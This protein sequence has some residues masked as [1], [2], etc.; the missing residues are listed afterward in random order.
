M[1]SVCANT[2]RM[3]VYVHVS[4]CARV[5]THTLLSCP[6]KAKRTACSPG[7]GAA[8]CAV[9]APAP[10]IARGQA[11]SVHVP[12]G[13]AAASRTASRPRATR[14]RRWHGH[15]ATA[16]QP[17]DAGPGGGCAA[18]TASSGARARRAADPPRAFVTGQHE[19]TSPTERFP[20]LPGDAVRKC[21]HCPEALQPRPSPA[22]HRGSSS[23]APTHAGVSGR[24]R[25]ALTAAT[26]HSHPAL[27]GPGTAC[28]SWAHEAARP[29]SLGLGQ[30]Q[31]PRGPREPEGR[32][33]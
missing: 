21:G 31:G 17:E 24:P 1:P 10:D 5:G 22:Q 18:A 28:H 14:Q 2:A 20:E 3:G 29:L 8:P 13:H 23:P 16:L 6:E 15:R 26:G 12:A 19:Q 11:P 30:G 33:Q 32:G 7:A 25:H 9:C 4:T 27:L